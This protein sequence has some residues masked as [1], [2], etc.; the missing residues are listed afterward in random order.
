MIC[1]WSTVKYYSAVEI[2]IK[3]CVNRKKGFGISKILFSKRL[4][5]WLL[6]LCLCHDKPL[7]KSCKFTLPTYSF[8]HLLLNQFSDTSTQYSQTVHLNTCTNMKDYLTLFPVIPSLL[9]SQ[10]KV[11][12]IHKYHTVSLMYIKI[13]SIKLHSV[14]FLFLKQLAYTCINHVIKQFWSSK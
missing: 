5:L 6:L 14:P 2:Y 12:S 9:C 10:H 8:K 3:S 4:N 11:V 7:W 1:S 13:T